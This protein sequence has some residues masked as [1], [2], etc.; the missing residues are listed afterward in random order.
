MEIELILS[1]LT[2]SLILS[3][4]PGPDNIFVLTESVSSGQRSGLS[5]SLGLSLGVMIHTLAAALGL[6]IVI[7]QSVLIFSIIKY[8]GAAY[9]FYLAI[10]ALKT[11]PGGSKKDFTKGAER[12]SISQLIRKGFLMNVLNPKVSLFFIAFLP[13]FVSK[14]GFNISF[15]MII[16]GFIFMIQAWLVFSF[17][18]ILSGRLHRYLESPNFLTITKWSKFGVL[19]ILAGLLLTSDK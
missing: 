13:Q 19:T 4:M 2:A 12:K 15:Q 14:S 17:I 9:L 3:I 7:Q 10:S 18:A 11:K 8:L 6:S 1:F 5:I 16:L